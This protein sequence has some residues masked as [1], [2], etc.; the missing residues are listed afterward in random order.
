MNHPLPVV[1]E[2]R[3]AVQIVPALIGVILSGASLVADGASARHFPVPHSGP[4]DES[5]VTT[6][7]F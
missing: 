2:R 7:V 5:R 4:V 1:A 6:I 3:T